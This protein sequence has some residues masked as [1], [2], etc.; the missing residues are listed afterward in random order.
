MQYHTPMQSHD[1]FY[2]LEKTD[3]YQ[4]LIMK[5]DTTYVLFCYFRLMHVGNFRTLATEFS[6]N[7]FYYLF[8]T[9]DKGKTDTCLK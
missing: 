4:T 9:K 5:F 2:D 3:E 6:G 8:V 1:P 7:E